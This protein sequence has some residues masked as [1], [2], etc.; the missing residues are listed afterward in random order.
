MSTIP[1]AW[2]TDFSVPVGWMR[3][4]KYFAELFGK[5]HGLPGDVVE[6]GLGKG[7]T[8]SMLAYL[9]GAE[10]DRTRKLWGFDS[11][12]GWPQP[13]KWDKSPR[14][15]RKGEWKVDQEM[16]TN[17]LRES[18]IYDQFPD[19][20]VRTVKGFF[21]KSLP[22]FPARSIAFLHIDADLYAGYRDALT[23]LYPKVVPG[24]IVAF[25]EYKEFPKDHG[26]ASYGGG[27][28]EKW[29]GATKAVDDYFAKRSEI[30][31]YHPETKKYY[32]VKKKR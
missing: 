29:P 7:S 31:Q 14:N 11:F 1:T 19:L 6:C 17:R 8:F 3:Q 30:I 16:I 13:T 5:I 23:F 28:I 32:V 25:D 9:I 4:F 15:P 26:G 20:D 2:A 12:E 22:H 21:S 24:G 18:G 10:S 27:T